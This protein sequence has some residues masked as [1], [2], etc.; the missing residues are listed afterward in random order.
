MNVQHRSNATAAIGYVRVSTGKQEL[1]L[2][3]QTEKLRAMS[4]V[5]DANFL[6]IIEDSE[7]AK[8]LDRPGMDRLRAL[9]NAGRVQVVIIAKLDRLTRSVRDLDVLLQEFKRH[10]V[11]LVSLAESLDTETASGRMVLNMLTTIAQ[12]E[13]E[14]IGERTATV[15]Q[16]K[17]AHGKVYNH[18]PY[19]YR[20]EGGDLVAVPA[21]QAVIA[22]I[23]RSNEAGASL[24]EIAGD[25]NREGVPTKQGRAWQAQTVKDVLR[26]NQEAA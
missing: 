7:S 26:L 19:G 5:K 10:G 13:R 2:E 15:L 14:V 24:R 16:H 1:S 12:W 6:E 4:V 25:L 20:R 18:V 21:E 3:A 9:V 8:T 23:R 22:D 11:A 17:R